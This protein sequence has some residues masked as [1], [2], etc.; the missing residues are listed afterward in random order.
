[1]TGLP[2]NLRSIVDAEYPRFSDGEMAR[3]RGAIETLLAQA[4]CDH[5]IFCGANRFGSSR[6]LLRGAEGSGDSPV[7]SVVI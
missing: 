7:Q 5:L 3:R 6:R 4:Q 2:P 1:M